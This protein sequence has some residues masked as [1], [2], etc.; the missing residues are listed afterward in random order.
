MEPTPSCGAVLAAKLISECVPCRSG[1]FSAG[2]GSTVCKTCPD[3]GSR[4]I[5][6]SCTTERD[7]ESKECPWSHFKDQMT[8]TCK[9]CSF[10]CGINATAHL[11]CILS[12]KCKGNCSQT[13]KS[14]R[15]FT[16]P[17]SIFR[18]VVT[19]FMHKAQTATPVRNFNTGQENQQERSILLEKR[20]IEQPT[21]S[22]IIKTDINEKVSNREDTMGSNN[23]ETEIIYN[24]SVS[25]GQNGKENEDLQSFIRPDISGSTQAQTNGI[26]TIQPDNTSYNFIRNDPK[27]NV[28]DAVQT[29]GRPISTTVKPTVSPS[30]PSKVHLKQLMPP[31]QVPTQMSLVASTIVMQQQPLINISSFLGS[32]LGTIA[33]FGVIGC[34]GIIAYIIFRK[35]T[36][37]PSG[38]KELSGT[39]S[40]WEHQI[41]GKDAVPN[42][43]TFI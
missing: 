40:L 13:A 36:R 29:E 35:C 12:K 25:K 1:T 43:I 32:F 18:R 33:A 26:P 20:G 34:I 41:K 4:K 8:H 9:H 30:M 24:L 7:A 27:N 11:R 15:K 14:T 17:H 5:V 31:T 6:T 2:T 10:C 23:K 28:D 21:L 42:I 22:E 39:G 37:G 3:C 19:K 38:Y 16:K